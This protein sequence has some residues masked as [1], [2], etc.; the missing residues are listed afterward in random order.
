MTAMKKNKGT[1]ISMVNLLD[2]CGGDKTFI[3]E[4]M[5]L[6][7]AQADSQITDIENALSDPDC[8]MLK[9][10]AHKFKSSAQLFEISQL[11]NILLQIESTGLTGL[12]LEEKK[13]ILKKVRDISD[14]A[15]EQVREERKN[16]T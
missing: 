10:S 13:N 1:I 16:Y 6:F 9:K 3:L 15:C 8:T 5:D 7:L 11:V 12:S 14:V 4:M 2:I